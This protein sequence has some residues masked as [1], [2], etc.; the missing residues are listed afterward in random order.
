S[1]FR[2]S[3]DP[4]A[5]WAP[6]VGFYWVD[7]AAETAIE[8][9]KRQEISTVIL[10]LVSHKHIFQLLNNVLYQIS[11]CHL[12]GSRNC[13]QCPRCSFGRRYACN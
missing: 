3:Q 13:H 11:S 10:Q 2:S 4:E 8:H 5:I 7:I 6:R 1:G 9:Y 12:C